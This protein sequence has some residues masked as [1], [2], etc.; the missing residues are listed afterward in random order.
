MLSQPVDLSAL[1]TLSQQRPEEFL[2]DD[3]LDV[4]V[5]KLLNCHNPRRC[6]RATRL[7]CLAVLS[8]V[9]CDRGGSGFG[10]S[11]GDRSSGGGERR[12]MVC[13]CLM[14]VSEWFD[15]Y[16]RGEATDAAAAADAADPKGGGGGNGCAAIGVG[17]EEPELHKAML[18]LLARAWN[19]T[20]VTEDLLEQTSG[21]LMLALETVIGV[22]EDGESYTTGLRQRQAPGDGRNGQ[23]E[24]ELVCHRYEKPLVLQL[25]RLVKGFTHPGTYLRACEPSRPAAPGEAKRSDKETGD[26]TNSDEYRVE[27]FSGE[28][29]SLLEIVLQSHAVDKLSVALHACLFAP[30]G[31]SSG[32]GNNG[33]GLGW[34]RGGGGDC[35]D[36]DVDGGHAAE[37]KVSF[38]PISKI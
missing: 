37:C 14:G 1:V 33:N 15:A 27:Q 30:L 9:A 5:S 19:Y 25:C 38:L 21:N 31:E 23:W 17:V 24:H 16:L 10:G 28:M 3:T 26:G 29:D 36:E 13:R 18:V 6:N 2:E 7:D 35:S 34:G 4:M 22:L 11:S 8:N 32:G 12:A 20:I